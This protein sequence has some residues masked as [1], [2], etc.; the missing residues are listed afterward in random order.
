MEKVFKMKIIYYDVWD[1]DL[2][3]NNQMKNRWCTECTIDEG[4]RWN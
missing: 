3:C 4:I 2:Q 1:E